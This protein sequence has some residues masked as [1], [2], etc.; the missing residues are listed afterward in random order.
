MK[1]KIL[2]I[3]CLFVIAAT[4][5][6]ANANEQKSVIEGYDDLI[7]TTEYDHK[8]LIEKGFIEIQDNSNSKYI[9]YV[10]SITFLDKK[11]DLVL[12]ILPD[13]SLHSICINFDNYAVD[14]FGLDIEKMIL[15]V[16]KS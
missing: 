4:L 11:T 3:I 1:K 8:T 10:K 13:R 9:E 14:N 6:I 5:K 15:F 12:A 2:L 16:K 7:L